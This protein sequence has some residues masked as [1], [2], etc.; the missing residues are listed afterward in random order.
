MKIIKVISLILIVAVVFSGCSLNFF[1]V[2]S[3][4]TPPSQGGENGEIQ[5]AFSKAM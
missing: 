4:L 1:S 5:D 3:L 2:E